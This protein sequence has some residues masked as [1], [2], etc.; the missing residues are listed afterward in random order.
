[1]DDGLPAIGRMTPSWVDFFIM[2][3][4][5][6]L[7]GIGAI[8]WIVFF[9]KP[10]RRRRKH[11]HRHERRLPKNTLAQNGGLPPV[12]REERPPPRPPPTPQ[13]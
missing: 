2:V 3:G 8:I 6:A 12:R 11:R 5:F 9:R 4:A 1:M 13:A 10:G 7:V